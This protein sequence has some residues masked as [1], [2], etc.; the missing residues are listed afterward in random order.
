LTALGVGELSVAF[1]LFC[2]QAGHSLRKARAELDATQRD[3][4]SE[5][6][7]WLLSN[8]QVSQLLAKDPLR[9]ALGDFELCAPKSWV[10]RLLGGLSGSAR[11]SPAE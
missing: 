8:P 7:T 3:Q 9:L 10:L 2:K 4:L 6:E 1:A 11:V 5:A